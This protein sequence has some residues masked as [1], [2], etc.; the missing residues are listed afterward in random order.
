MNKH[1]LHIYWKKGPIFF[2]IILFSTSTLGALSLR[3]PAFGHWLVIFIDG[4][5]F[6]RFM[7]VH[8]VMR[9]QK[10]W[11]YISIKN[12]WKKIILH[13]FI[14]HHATVCSISEARLKVFVGRLNITEAEFF[15][16]AFGKV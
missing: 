8:Q 13:R 3:K 12:V 1:E 5:S 4:L 11:I 14:N 9:V 2:Y 16:K 6:L 7:I 15:N 10:F